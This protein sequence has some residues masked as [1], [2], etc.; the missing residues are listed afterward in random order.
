MNLDLKLYTLVEEELALLLEKLAA[1]LINGRASD[2]S[3]YRYR[4]GRI[5]GIREALEVAKDANR[6]AI[7]LEDKEER[8]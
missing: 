4:V 7:G 6:R 1:E 2:Y 3:D 5:H 8:N